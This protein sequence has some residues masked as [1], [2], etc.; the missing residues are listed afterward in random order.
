[1]SKNGFLPPSFAVVHHRSGIPRRALVVNFVLGI[2][3][4]LPFGSWQQIVAATSVL[5]LIAYA[6]PSVSAVVF[7]RGDAFPGG[8]PRWVRY[9]APAAFVLATLIIYWAGWHELRIA[10]PILLVGVLVYAYQHWRAG[11]EWADARLG[12]WLVGYLALVLLMSGIG[13]ADFEG[14][15]AVP[16]PWDSVGVAVIALAAWLAGVRAGQRY[17][18]AHPAPEAEPQPDRAPGRPAAA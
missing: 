10:L 1:M 15:N 5:G 13:S 11:A 18:V 14:A 16:A 7:D 9:L 2:V 12:A 17:L 8:A 4:L 3:F 6:L